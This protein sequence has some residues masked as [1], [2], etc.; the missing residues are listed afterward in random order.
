MHDSDRM[1]AIFEVKSSLTY[2][3]LQQLI[4]SPSYLCIITH[5]HLIITVSTTF[6]VFLSLFRFI[7]VVTFFRRR[8]HCYGQ[9]VRMSLTE[10]LLCPTRWNNSKRLSSDYYQDT[11]Q[12]DNKKKKVFRSG[13]KITR[14]FRLKLVHIRFHP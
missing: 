4:K 2:T 3:Q 8:G 5:I 12:E 14:V 7:H 10:L 11:L 13:R 6:I 1:F 9:N